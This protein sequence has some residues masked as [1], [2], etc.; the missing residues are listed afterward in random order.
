M[1]LFIESGQ[2]SSPICLVCCDNKAVTKQTEKFIFNGS[3]NL[4]LNVKHTVTVT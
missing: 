4:V 3:T 1:L 2:I